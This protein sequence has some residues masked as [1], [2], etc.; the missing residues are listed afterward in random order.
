MSFGSWALT[1][2]VRQLEA[3][4]FAGHPSIYLSERLC[5]RA[6]LRVTSL[7][8]L[9]LPAASFPPSEEQSGNERSGAEQPT[10]RYSVERK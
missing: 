9:R 1:E 8:L 7:L 2:P 6:P 5:L 10:V 4:L 3:S